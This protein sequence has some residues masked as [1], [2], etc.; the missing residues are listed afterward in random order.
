LL[1]ACGPSSSAPPD[2][3]VLDAPRTDDA[4]A[5]APP[6]GCDYTEQHD[7]TN[8][9]VSDPPGTPEQTGLTAGARTVVCGNFEHTHFDGDITADID[10]YV[11]SVPSETDVLV[12]LHGAGAE[13]IEYAGVDVY[14]GATFGTLVGSATFY[15]DHGVA[16]LHLPAGSYELAAF[17]LSSAALSSTIAYELEVTTDTPATRCPEVASGGYAETHDGAD[18][19]DNDVVTIPDGA[20][21]ALTASATDAPEPTG[22]TLE[23][24]AT[25]GRRHDDGS[26]RGQGHV[27]VHDRRVDERARR[28]ADVAG[29]R[30]EPR[31]PRVRG[32]R[33]EPGV[34]RDRDR[35][36]GARA[37]HVLRQAEHQLL[38]ARRREDR[39]RGPPG[40]LRG[41][42][43]QRR[44]RPVALA[45]ASCRASRS[46]YR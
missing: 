33:S 43:V 20:P 22:L 42:A 26:V 11:L 3:R 34:P 2:G 9:D 5:D 8:D 13:A 12:R 30:R 1:A 18:S 4:P 41:V 23:P 36:A 29:H 6:S 46:T 28:A 21:P 39:Q 14:G 38:A 10:G 45:T 7:A 40:H 17:A 24:G 32:R 25:R 44:V 27:R 37:A 19:T 15:G 16:A 31:L 35:A